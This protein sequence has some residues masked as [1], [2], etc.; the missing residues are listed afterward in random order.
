M[1]EIYDKRCGE[2]AG[3]RLKKGGA[4]PGRH[5]I[6][7]FLLHSE[8]GSTTG[9]L[10]AADNPGDGPHYKQAAMQVSIM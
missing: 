1:R 3:L 6:E 4:F 9:K 8:R 7:R 2:T 5:A 10:S